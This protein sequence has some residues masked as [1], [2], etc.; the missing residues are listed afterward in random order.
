MN[1]LR[2]DL[3]DTWALTLI[4]NVGNARITIRNTDTQEVLQQEELGA[5]LAAFYVPSVGMWGNTSVQLPVKYKGEGLP[6]GRIWSS[7]WSWPRS[8]MSTKT[9]PQTGTPWARARSELVPLTIDNTARRKFWKSPTT[10][11]A[12]P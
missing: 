11:S 6:E 12:T 2:G 3:L 5:V 9:A 10:W 1:N 4:R 8:C 7:P